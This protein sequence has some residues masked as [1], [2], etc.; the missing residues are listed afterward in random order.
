MPN[1]VPDDIV[2]KFQNSLQ[3][4]VKLDTTLQKYEQDGGD[5]KFIK[6]V[7]RSIGIDK[8]MMKITNKR[9]GSVILTM[10]IK[11][12]QSSSVDDLRSKLKNALHKDIA[13]PVLA[14]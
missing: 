11:G 6:D 14:I 3:M 7:T 4:T 2:K 12:D 8:S 13:Y 5:A 9:Q 1:S 10:E